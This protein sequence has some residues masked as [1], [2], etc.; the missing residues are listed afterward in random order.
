MSNSSANAGPRPAGTRGQAADA[1][2]LESGHD[3]WP[4]GW[5]EMNDPPQAVYVAGQIESLASP[6]LGIVGTRAATP[7]GLAVARGLAASLA[8]LG[9]TIVSGLARGI[10]AA[11]HDGALQAGGRTVAVMGTGIDLTYPAAHHRLRERIQ[12]RGCVLT[13]YEAGQ[14]PRPYHFPQRNRLL[15][16]LVRGLIV[17][18][19]PA[20]SGAL[21]TAYL[22]LDYAREVFAVP[23]PVDLES[24]RGCHRLLREGAH[25]VEGPQDV[26][27]LLGAPEPDPAAAPPA[28]GEHGPEPGSPAAWILERLDLEGV[29]RDRLRERWPG[30]E[31]NWQRGLLQLELAGLIRRLPG[32]RLARTIWRP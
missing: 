31:E 21:T 11:A 32:G 4:A 28:A 20:R 5:R 8:A 25:L 9:W 22:A 3:R 13:E 24:S 17:I 1:V 26:E 10:D 18:E 15:A 27:N 12:E 7:R 6:M 16:G 23:G 30:G 14:G 19:A 29:P 2:R